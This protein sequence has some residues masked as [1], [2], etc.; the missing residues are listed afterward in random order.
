[1]GR[2][3]TRMQIL[4][5]IQ[6]QMQTRTQTQLRIDSKEH[7]HLRTLCWYIL[8]ALS[9]YMLGS[10]TVMSSWEHGQYIGSVIHFGLCLIRIPPR[11][12][13]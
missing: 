11:E 3:Q 1:M 8:R 9:I 6:T 10:S 13:I 4:I 2:T 12:M 5:W 7:D